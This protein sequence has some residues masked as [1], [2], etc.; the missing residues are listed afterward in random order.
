MNTLALSSAV[1]MALLSVGPAF[2]ESAD[3]CKNNTDPQKFIEGKCNVLKGCDVIPGPL[4]EQRIQRNSTP[5]DMSKFRLAPKRRLRTATDQHL[6]GDSHKVE[7]IKPEIQIDLKLKN[8]AD[9]S[10]EP[11][12][13]S[14]P[15]VEIKKQ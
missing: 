7:E 9:A 1:V 6:N 4:K 3:E 11:A 10:M 14:Q 15:D 12:K 2:A 8:N 5:Q 13:Q